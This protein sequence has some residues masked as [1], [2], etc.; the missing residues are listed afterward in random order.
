MNAKVIEFPFRHGNPE[1]Q[2]VEV[3]KSAL[4]QNGKTMTDAEARKFTREFQAAREQS[5]R[6]TAGMTKGQRQE[7]LLDRLADAIRSAP[8]KL[9]S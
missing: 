8:R 1:D 9:E 7:Y 4:G 5:A 2:N 6:E 3:I